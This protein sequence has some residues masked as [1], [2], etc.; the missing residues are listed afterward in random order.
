MRNVGSSAALPRHVDIMCHVNI[1]CHVA[2]DLCVTCGDEM[3]EVPGTPGRRSTPDM[4]YCYNGNK[5]DRCTAVAVG[6]DNILE[7]KLRVPYSPA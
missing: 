7:K 2:Y 4:S 3:M 1:M 5:M 6:S